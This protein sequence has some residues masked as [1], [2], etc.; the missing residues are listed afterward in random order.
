MQLKILNSHT[1][2]DRLAVSIKAIAILSATIA[3]YFQDLT[4]IAND[5]IQGDLTSYILAIP[6][7]FVYLIYRKRQMLK[8]AV[9]LDT[10]SPNRKQTYTRETVGFLLCLIAFLLYWHGSYTFYP[11]EYHIM[12]LPLFTAGLILIIF[13]TKT[14]RVLAF[15]IAFLLFITPPPTEIAS[16]AG[17]SVATF[18]SDVSYNILKTIG[19]QSAKYLSMEHQLLL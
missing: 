9:S 3:I 19:L 10:I 16:I 17:A 12:S 18:S 14:L 2:H 1:T 13:N 6:L 7:L 11:L 15:P 8:A 4:I 5:A